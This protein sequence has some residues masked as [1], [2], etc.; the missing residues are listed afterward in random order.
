MTEYRT[1]LSRDD[2]GPMSISAEIAVRDLGGAITHAL[3]PGGGE[4][5]LPT[6]N[7][8]LQCPHL[9]SPDG[10]ISASS[11]TPAPQEGQE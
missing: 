3:T 2:D 9:T 7:Q 6:L 5:S 11:P 8:L 10:E 1:D 4:D